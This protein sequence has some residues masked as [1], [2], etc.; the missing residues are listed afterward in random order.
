MPVTVAE[1]RCTDTTGGG[2]DKT[3][4]FSAARHDPK[5]VRI[6][7]FFLAHEGDPLPGITAFARESGVEP[8][9]VPDRMKLDP[10]LLGD[11]RRRLREHGCDLIHTHDFKTDFWGLVLARTTPG[12]GLMATAHGWS[13]PLARSHRF[14]NALDRRVLRAFPLV[15]AVSETTGEKLRGM[16]I[17]PE[18]IEVLP[19]G[20]DLEAW[21]PRPRPDPLPPGL[22]AGGRFVG[23][24]GRLSIDKAVDTLIEAFGA[25]VPRFENLHLVL[26]GDG[27]ERPRLEA[28]A[29]ARGVAGRVLFLGHRTDLRELYAAF[30]L[31]ALSSRTE[32]MP[33]TL[34]EAMAM[35]RPVVATPVGGVGE[36]V[37]DRQEALLVPPGRSAPL[38]E[39]MAEVLDNDVLAASLARAGRRRVESSFSFTGR[40]ARL[41][42]LYERMAGVGEPEAGRLGSR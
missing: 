22:P 42:T 39:A 9:R 34:L 18:R 30:D 32:G 33:N 14:F 6:V 20:I 4:L 38:A 23:T 2:P 28:L 26:V 1:F 13:N 7:P 25:L 41:E 5:R 3:I 10:R 15:I 17:R 8:V 36:V 27:P 24:V 19:N 12:L 11:M 16:G 40:L 29:T 31:F 35:A 21:S 37:R